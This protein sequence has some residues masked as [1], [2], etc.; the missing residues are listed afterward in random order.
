MN[1]IIESRKMVYNNFEKVC[2]YGNEEEIS[3]YIKEFNIDVNYDDGYYFEI[4]CIRNNLDL[5]KLM[6]K[7]GANVHI[8]DEYAI[9]YIAQEGHIE[10]LE[11]LMDN[12]DINYK[13]L[14]MTTAC[15]N[16]PLTANVLKRYGIIGC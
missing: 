2:M 15:S 11:Y 7:N 1:Y 5:L 14:C 12:Y 8:N 13:D 6:I 16:N 9:K 4:I 3:A 10:M